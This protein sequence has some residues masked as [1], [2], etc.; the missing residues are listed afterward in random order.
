MIIFLV[1][2][3][4]LTFSSSEICWYSHFY[5]D[6]SRQQESLKL[7]LLESQSFNEKRREQYERM[8]EEIKEGKDKLV[9][10][11]RHIDEE[12]HALAAEN[13]ALQQRIEEV[14]SEMRVGESPKT[15]EG[16]G[17]V[18]SEASTSFFENRRC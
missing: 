13:V 18:V 3:L 4:F 5:G 12:V 7:A 1:L 8:Q 9:E 17:K 2:T 15:E 16:E 14:L 11:Q 6:L 10:Q